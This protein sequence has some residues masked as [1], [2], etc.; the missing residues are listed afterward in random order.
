MQERFRTYIHHGSDLSVWALVS[1][2]R[3][4]SASPQCLWQ[5]LEA[6]LPPSERKVGILSGCHFLTHM[7]IQSIALSRN[8]RVSFLPYQIF[9]EQKPPWHVLV[10]RPCLFLPSDYRHHTRFVIPPSPIPST[11][12]RSSRARQQTHTTAETIPDPETC[13]G[14]RERLRICHLKGNTS[15]LFKV[16]RNLP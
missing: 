14:S 13:C 4:K 8:K 9:V 6:S 5:A 11:T 10:Y 16:V 15:F 7:V 2:F 12:C 1:Q 3:L